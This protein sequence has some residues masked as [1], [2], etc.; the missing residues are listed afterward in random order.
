[1]ST[2]F[3]P[4]IFREYDIRGIAETELTDEVAVMVG[5]AYGTYMRRAGAR[6]VTV[7]QDVRLSSPRLAEHLA[8]GILSTGLDVTRLG[9]TP[10]PALYCSIAQLKTDGG[11][12]VTGSHNPIEYNGFK[13]CQGLGSVFGEAIQG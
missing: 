13:M 4:L 8:E 7:G 2:R 9:V 10:T 1:M 5:R 12:Q 6:H 11:V 3:N